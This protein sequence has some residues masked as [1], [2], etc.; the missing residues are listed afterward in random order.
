MKTKKAP[1]PTTKTAQ[2]ALKRQIA[3][4]ALAV[5]NMAAQ[6]DPEIY[7]L[8]Y[9]EICSREELHTL[10]YINLFS[11]IVANILGFSVKF[12]EK[13]EDKQFLLSQ[14]AAI[15]FKISKKH[16]VDLVLSDIPKIEQCM[17]MT[18]EGSIQ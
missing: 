1:K 6:L 10:D 11:S 15:C 12:F 8:I 18:N 16:N 17:E 4:R 14:V 7:T 3:N 13:E 9:N 2:K 5:Q